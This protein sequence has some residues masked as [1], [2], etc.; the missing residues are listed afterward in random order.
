MGNGET[1]RGEERRTLLT[2]AI[3]VHGMNQNTL[4]SS[5]VGH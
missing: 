3:N 2:A 4:L 1:W 5:V